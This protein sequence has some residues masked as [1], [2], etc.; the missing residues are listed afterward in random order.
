M[1][2]SAHCSNKG[3]EALLTAFRIDAPIRAKT[4]DWSRSTEVD[5]EITQ[6]VAQL[7]DQEIEKSKKRIEWLKDQKY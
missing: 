4:I 5:D 1:S 7:L 2:K 6:Q 3:C